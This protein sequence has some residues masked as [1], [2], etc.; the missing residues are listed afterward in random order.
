MHDLAVSLFLRERGLPIYRPP[1]TPFAP[2]NPVH[3]SSGEGQEG[4]KGGERKG[5]AGKGKDEMKWRV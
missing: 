2:V 5:G 4:S 1:L 3:S